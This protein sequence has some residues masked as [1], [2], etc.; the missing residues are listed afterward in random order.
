MGKNHP[1]LLRIILVKF[2]WAESEHLEFYNEQKNIIEDIKESVKTVLF[3][4]HQ[5][6]KLEDEIRSDIKMYFWNCW[7]ALCVCL[8][9]IHQHCVLDYSLHLA[10]F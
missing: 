9:L 6:V 7:H 5:M 8:T 3:S 2:F 10:Q 1:S 4:L